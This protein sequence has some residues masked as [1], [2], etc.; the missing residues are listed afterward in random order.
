MTRKQILSKLSQIVSPLDLKVI[1]MMDQSQL[2][3][4]FRSI[5]DKVCLM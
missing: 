5:S 2:D 1:K 3:K 4:Y